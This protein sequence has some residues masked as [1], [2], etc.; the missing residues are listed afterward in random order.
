MSAIDLEDLVEP[1]KQRKSHTSK[2]RHPRPLGSPSPARIPIK[3]QG[4]LKQFGYS[5][6]DSAQERHHALEEA[7]QKYGSLDVIQKVN[8]IANLQE[9]RPDGKIFRQDQKWLSAKYEKEKGAGEGPQAL[10]PNNVRWVKG[11][12]AG[13]E[14]EGAGGA[15]N[16][17]NWSISRYSA[18]RDELADAYGGRAAHKGWIPISESIIR[19]IPQAPP[20]P[21]LFH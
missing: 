18:Y 19:G 11:G 1:S 16:Q 3:H 13:T 6:K 10:W 12:L 2:H 8:A 20:E 5:A 7:E 9:H 15:N 17:L 21:I 4:D 14:W